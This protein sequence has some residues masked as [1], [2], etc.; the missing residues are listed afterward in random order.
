MHELDYLKIDIDRV[1]AYLLFSS[2]F[3]L[4]PQN[5]LLLTLAI[6][7][8]EFN[9]FRLVNLCLGSIWEHKQQ[10]ARINFVVDIEFFFFGGKTK[11]K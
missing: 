7:M 10:C 4:S 11:K 9:N 8:D 3:T 2:H 6:F 1:M 5:N